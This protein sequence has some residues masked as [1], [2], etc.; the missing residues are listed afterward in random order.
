MAGHLYRLPD[1]DMPPAIAAVSAA[2]RDRFRAVFLTRHITVLGLFSLLPARSDHLL[3]IVP[4]AVVMPDGL[5]ASIA[6]SPLVLP[7]IFMIVEGWSE[8]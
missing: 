7:V 2:V 6:F 3:L 4:F 1:G 5:I 8:V